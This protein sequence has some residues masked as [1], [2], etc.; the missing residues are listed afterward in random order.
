MMITILIGWLMID[1]DDDDD[2]D[3]E[4]EEETTGSHWKTTCWVS[5]LGKA[6]ESQ[7]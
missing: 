1:I 4:E 6:R 7:E 2:D 3:D 5:Q